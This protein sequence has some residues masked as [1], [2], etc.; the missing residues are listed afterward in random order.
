VNSIERQKRRKRRAQ[1]DA[2]PTPGQLD[3]LAR[4]DT[5]VQLAGYRAVVAK[6]PDTQLVE[7]M[8]YMQPPK[9]RWW[10]RRRVREQYERQARLKALEIDASL[11]DTRLSTL[12]RYA[13]AV[14]LR[15]HVPM[16]RLMPEPSIRSIQRALRSQERRQPRRGRRRLAF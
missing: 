11:V 7:R 12:Q 9:S 2:R 8:G 3:E 13:R 6:M 4:I 10:H 5:A 14:G 1:L 16:P 15:V